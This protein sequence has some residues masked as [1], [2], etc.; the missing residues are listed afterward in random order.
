MPILNN[1]YQANECSFCDGVCFNYV[2]H[3]LR[4]M[5]MTHLLSGM[6]YVEKYA[7]LDQTGS[8]VI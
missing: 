7:K 3:V 1:Q 6:Y 8:S 2:A 5:W 4:K